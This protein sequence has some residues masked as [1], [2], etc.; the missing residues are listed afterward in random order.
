MP[1]FTLCWAHI[2]Q[3]TVHFNQSHAS[4]EK[5]NKIFTRTCLWF[6]LWLEDVGNENKYENGTSWQAEYNE[7]Y[8]KS[9][10][11]LLWSDTLQKGSSW[12]AE[13]GLASGVVSSYFVA[14]YVESRSFWRCASWKF[15]ASASW[16][17]S[18]GGVRRIALF[19]ASCVVGIWRIARRIT[20][21]HG[22]VRWQ[23]FLPSSR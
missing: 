22:V 13:V 4:N 21:L 7:N 9:T 14:V 17:K 10:T 3:S 11:F 1:P 5:R 15:D 2:Y 19:L 12:G 16:D 6:L 20:I 23:S 8:N 18:W